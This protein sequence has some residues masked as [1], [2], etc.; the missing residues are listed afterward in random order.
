MA[1]PVRN[2]LDLTSYTLQDGGDVFPFETPA[3]DYPVTQR[4]MTSGLN[5]QTHRFENKDL[6]LPLG[7]ETHEAE[8]IFVR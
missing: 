7:C 5:F 4:R 6:T 2:I 3:I 8:K 1:A